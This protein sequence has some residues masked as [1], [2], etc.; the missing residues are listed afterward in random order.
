[1]IVFVGSVVHREATFVV[2]T[3]SKQ[4]YVGPPVGGGGFAN[5]S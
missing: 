4:Q 5:R 2:I 1:V 3:P